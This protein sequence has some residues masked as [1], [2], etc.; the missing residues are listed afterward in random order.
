MTTWRVGLLVWLAILLTVPTAQAGSVYFMTGLEE[1]GDATNV[2][3]P[4]I[5][6]TSGSATIDAVIRRTGTYSIQIASG[7]FRQ[8]KDT[9]GTTRDTLFL[10]GYAYMAA[11][12]SSDTTIWETRTSA[13]AIINQLWITTTGTLAFAYNNGAYVATS[14]GFFIP[15]Q[16]NLIETKLVRSATVG[17]M[18]LKLNG[19]TEFTSFGTNTGAVTQCQLT[20]GPYQGGGQAI[21]F[22]DILVLTGSYPGPGQIIARQGTPGTPSHTGVWTLTGGTIDVVWSDTPFNPATNAAISTSLS[23]QRQSML[24]APFSSVQAGHGS[25]VIRTGDTI[26]AAL[27]VYIMKSTASLNLPITLNGIDRQVSSQRDCSSACT[28]DTWNTGSYNDSN[29]YSITPAHLDSAEVGGSTQN[30]GAATYQ[31][32]DAWLMVDYT[33]GAAGT[34]VRVRQN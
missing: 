2:T 8:Y 25:E 29:G 31:I 19:V 16:W 14:T 10:R 26:N 32:E 12:P 6:A 21:N 22:D 15:G 17:G 5:G 27:G 11:Y 30:A 33:P 23:G 34:P 28:A 7:G 3:G 18:E 9:C 1:G 4:F 24:V 13:A 20:Y